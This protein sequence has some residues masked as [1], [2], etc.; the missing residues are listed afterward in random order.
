MDYNI[1]DIMLE[2][3]LEPKTLLK[4][5]FLLNT[6]KNGAIRLLQGV[7]F[8]LSHKIVKALT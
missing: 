4:S 3:K 8:V 2:P 1:F 6:T 5:I 7:W